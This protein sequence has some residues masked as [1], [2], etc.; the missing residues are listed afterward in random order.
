MIPVSLFL[1]FAFGYFLGHLF[2]VI[3]AVVG[4]AISAELGIDTAALGFLTS[5]YF[6]AF[7]AAQLP[8]GMLLDRFGANR[9]QGVLL[10]VA[11]AGA[12]VFAL[13][14]DIVSLSIG[15]ALIGLGVS[16]GLMAAFKAY[17]ERLPAARLP[18]ANGL[19]LAAGSLGVLV[20]GLPVELAMTAIGWR[21]VFMCLAVLSLIA[22]AVLFF[23]VSDIAEPRRRDSFRSLIGG[24][25]TVVGSS[26]FIR[27]A[28]LSVATQASGLALIALWV[29]PWLRNVAGY[30]PAEAATVLSLIG[31]AMI[32]GYVLCGLATNKL[33]S[34]GV[35]LPVV[36]IGGYLLYFATQ[37]VIIL[38]EPAWSAPV[39]LVFALLVSTGTLSYP[40]LAAHFPGAMT[41]R[42]HTA[43][44]FL[45][46]AA[47]FAFQWVFGVVVELLLP[48]VD[49]D[50]AYD[51]A[52]WGLVGL[53]AAGYIWYAVW[54]P[55]RSQALAE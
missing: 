50:T 34:L 40:A 30:P 32:A 31:V 53:Q 6:L 35:P 15:R 26:P 36:M 43:L 49:V 51:V 17:S 8:L 9:V 54:R 22:A 7:A 55:A 3:N 45:V 38:I 5:V 27:L 39:W 14:D 23:G 42:V 28:P 24:V 33:I 37:P 19:H 44:N 11:A 16:S 47:A 48:V 20:G 10:T 41:G 18:L 12:V 2:R 52:L 25:V 1:A 21:G 29:G 4:P 13:G 46:F